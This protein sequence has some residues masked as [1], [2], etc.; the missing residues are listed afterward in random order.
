M[1]KEIGIVAL[2]DAKT[3]KTT[4]LKQINAKLKPAENNTASYA[5]S[6]YQQTK[7]KLI[8]TPSVESRDDQ[9]D[10]FIR[11]AQIAVVFFDLQNHASFERAKALVL[12]CQRA[13]EDISITLYG[14]TK[15]KQA[16]A[17][18]LE[19]AQAFA[20]QQGCKFRLGELKTGKL[21]E[22]II[23]HATT[24]NSTAPAKTAV[25]RPNNNRLEIAKQRYQHF[26]RKPSSTCFTFFAKPKKPTS[27]SDYKV[28]VRNILADYV[29]YSCCGSWLSRLSRIFSGHWNRHH[30][31]EV[32]QLIQE[33]DTTAITLNQTLARLNGIQ[34]K[35]HFNHTGS[36]AMRISFIK[37]QLTGVRAVELV[38]LNDANLN[39]EPG[40]FSFY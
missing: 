6:E 19:K 21:K 20:R 33:L 7:L 26:W 17:G 8:D 22:S 9:Y 34:T 13:K 40:R 37:Q 36:L 29:K 10:M 3:G 25:R 5:H 4:F 31:T 12:R 39:E 11:Q 27:T 16:D 24:L 35:L 30:I 28:C 1:G 18:L 15:G 2:G 23:S 32:T 14:N 38:N